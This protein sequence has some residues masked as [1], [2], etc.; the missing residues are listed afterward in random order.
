MK[1]HNDIYRVAKKR[2]NIGKYTDTKTKRTCVIAKN[3]IAKIAK[4]K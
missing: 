2:T 4:T 3:N 1:E